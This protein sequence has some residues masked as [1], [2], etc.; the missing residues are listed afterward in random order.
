MNTTKRTLIK[1]ARPTPGRSFIQAA[2]LTLGLI[3]AGMLSPLPALAGPDLDITQLEIEGTPKVGKCNTAIVRVK[4]VGNQSI[5]TTTKTSVVANKA[6]G[7]GQGQIHYVD[8]GATQPGKAQ[9]QRIKNFEIASPGQWSLHAVADSGQQIKEDNEKNNRETKRITVKQKCSGNN[10]ELPDFYS[11]TVQNANTSG[12]QG[13]WRYGSCKNSVKAVVKNLGADYVYNQEYQ[14]AQGKVTAGQILVQFQL[15]KNNAPQ[16]SPQTKF[17]NKLDKNE[18]Q[19]VVFPNT[20]FSTS[21]N[22]GLKTTIFGCQKGAS[23]S[24]C[25]RVPE[26]KTNNNATTLNITVNQACQ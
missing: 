16:G 10:D 15:L 5:T 1:T 14:T 23:T 22:Y 9:L 17:L 7:G 11:L 20:Y 13:L 24:N 2:S 19:E 4:N 3:G 12:P 26:K 25:Q 18:V 6:S 21:G 8:I